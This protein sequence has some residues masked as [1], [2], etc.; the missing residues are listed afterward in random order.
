MPQ[1]T[2]AER[3]V[4]K[5]LENLTIAAMQDADSF[6]GLTAAPIVKVPH[7]NGSYYEYSV[8]DWN[9]HDMQKRGSS[10]LSAE[11][12]WSNSNTSYD[13]IRYAVGHPEDWTDAADAD[14]AFNVDEDSA[15]WLANQ[16][17]IHL[18]YLWTA[19]AGKTGVWTTDWDGK[20]SSPSTN[21]FL[22]F[23]QA[24]SD[25]L[26]T[27]LKAKEAV[28]ALIGKH[29]NCIIA[30]R[31]ANIGI[32]TNAAVRDAFKGFASTGAKDM[33]AAKLANYFGVETYRVARSFYNS[34]KEGQTAS[35]ASLFGTKDLWLGY[36]QP[37]PGK[38]KI[39]AC[40]TFAWIG[41]D[42]VASENG[43]VTR[44]FDIPERTTTK[45]EVEMFVVV[46]VIAASAGA[47]LED[48]VA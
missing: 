45:A 46:K 24:T 22:Q 27:I 8:G 15:E 43:I 23:D 5:P 31:D 21:E 6:I 17:N 41:P 33:S 34:A 7:Q 44:R 25:P 16:A 36:V 39:S 48:A 28:H 35:L 30:G 38:K 11:S 32:Q 29:P 47:F 14:A 4:S 20:S 9:R 42:G 26:Q 10:E 19:E 13:C 2:R 40:Y 1:P 3:N 37:N 12:G 18:D